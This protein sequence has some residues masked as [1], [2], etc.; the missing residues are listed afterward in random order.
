MSTTD[1]LTE[2]GV[3]ELSLETAQDALLDAYER[4]D[5]L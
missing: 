2:L 5:P 3:G 1:E 4:L